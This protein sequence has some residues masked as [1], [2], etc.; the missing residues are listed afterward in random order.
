LYVLLSTSV[1]TVAK[2]NSAAFVLGAQRNRRKESKNENERSLFLTDI[3]SPR[4][5]KKACQGL[6]KFIII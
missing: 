4:E 1:L 2:I 5:M 3:Y 6:T